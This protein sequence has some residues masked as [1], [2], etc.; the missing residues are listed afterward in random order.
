MFSI[1]RN[2]IQRLPPSFDQFQELTLFKVDGNP[3]EWPPKSVL[4]TSDNLDDPQAMKEWIVRVQ[5]WIGGNS[6]SRKMSEDSLRHDRFRDDSDA[7]RY[8]LAPHAYILHLTNL[9][10]ANIAYRR[11]RWLRLPEK[12]SILPPLTMLVL[13]PLS[14]RCRPTSSSTARSRVAS[15]Q[16]LV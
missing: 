6:P 3:L 14:P 11:L 16:N 12:N 13:T 2:K 8:A 9:F 10:I 15:L 7:A 5:K 1:L 4:D